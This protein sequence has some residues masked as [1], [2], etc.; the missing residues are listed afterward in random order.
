MP[1][2]DRAI[3]GNLHAVKADEDVIRL[4]YA[5][6]GGSGRDMAQQH[7]LLPAAHAVEEPHGPGLHA[8]E[9][10]AQVGEA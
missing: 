3:V 10:Y 6:S 5:G 9:P 7:T 8:L 2:R 4:Q 1:E